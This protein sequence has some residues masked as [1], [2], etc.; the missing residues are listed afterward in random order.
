MGLY[1]FF[2]INL[3]YGL[4]KKS[5]GQWYAYNREY[6]PLGFTNYGN[7]TELSKYRNGL[8]YG[9]HWDLPIGSFYKG[10]TDKKIL[11]IAEGDVK[12]ND[13]GEIIQFWL[14]NDSCAP[15]SIYGNNKPYE[16]KEYC[17]KLEKL[18]KL[19]VK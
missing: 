17:I 13:N 8:Q 15:F 6:S 12:R 2:R 9:D 5:N 4:L 16:W 19:M 1:N 10:L 7:S 11:E 18:A 14:Y 3:P